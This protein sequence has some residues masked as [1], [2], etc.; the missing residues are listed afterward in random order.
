MS[1]GLKYVVRADVP[2]EPAA[3]YQYSRPWVPETLGPAGSTAA[4]RPM[5]Y[6]AEDRTR[7]LPRI[8]ETRK[9]RGGSGPDRP[10][11]W[12]GLGQPVTGGPRGRAAH[13]GMPRGVDCAA[14][15]PAFGPP[16]TEPGRSQWHCDCA[17]LDSEPASGPSPPS[18][19]TGP[20][21]RAVHSV[22]ARGVDCAALEPAFGPPP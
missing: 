3:G 19:L 22:T 8:P 10:G 11:P 15:E 16:H 13:S 1:G 18:P 2:R 4:E 6:P 7:P 17:A 21:G 20:R 9:I 5:A 14:L 12:L